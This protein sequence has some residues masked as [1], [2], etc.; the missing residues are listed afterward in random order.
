MRACVVA[1]CNS[2]TQARIRLGGCGLTLAWQCWWCMCVMRVGGGAL[3][4]KRMALRCVS[5]HACNA[6]AVRPRGA[7]FFVV[8]FICG[9]TTAEA[10]AGMAGASYNHHT[11]S[12]S[13][14]GAEQQ[15]SSPSSLPDP[16]RQA[17]RHHTTPTSSLLRP[18]CAHSRH[19]TPPAHASLSVQQQ[20]VQPATMAAVS[21]LWLGVRAGVGIAATIAL[22]SAGLVLSLLSGLLP[23]R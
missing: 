6:S 3:D 5:V 22:G 7:A 12:V 2:C 15:Q 10:A 14:A 9:A 19:P 1:A 18:C 4:S 8:L 21:P 13:S 16:H 11:C 23:A 17:A 20:R